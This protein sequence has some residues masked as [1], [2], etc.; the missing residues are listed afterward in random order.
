MFILLTILNCINLVIVILVWGLD[1][2][3][4]LNTQSS[5]QLNFKILLS[6][7]C[8]IFL[9]TMLVNIV[10]LENTSF[11]LIRLLPSIAE[12]LFIIR[13]FNKYILFL[14]LAKERTILIKLF[15][16]LVVTRVCMAYFYLSTSLYA[17]IV[18]IGVEVLLS[19]LFIYSAKVYLSHLSFLMTQELPTWSEDNYRE[20]VEIFQITTF[21]KRVHIICSLAL[22]TFI[23]NGSIWVFGRN[24]YMSIPELEF[25]L[26]FECISIYTRVIPHFLMVFNYLWLYIRDK[27]HLRKDKN[28]VFEL[29]EVLLA[30][31]E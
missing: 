22:H 16:G 4:R 21:H 1:V 20:D 8:L 19:V 17:H 31:D 11:L 2:T 6:L 15:V 10:E 27:N 12:W 28:F 7:T 29:K 14:H 23:L 26:E 30:H 24:L 18:V 13:L 9:E 25:T 5:E 3:G